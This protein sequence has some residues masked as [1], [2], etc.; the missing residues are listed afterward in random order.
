MWGASETTISMTVRL[1]LEHLWE[2]W[3]ARFR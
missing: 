1:A 3:L 2:S